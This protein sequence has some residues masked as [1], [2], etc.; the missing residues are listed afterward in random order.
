MKNTRKREF[1]RQMEQVVPWQELQALIAPH[2][3][4][5]GP[6]GGR[7]AYSVAVL[8]R[9]HFLQQW[10]AL[11]DPA[12]EEALYD[13]PVFAEFVG[14]DLGVDTVPDESTILRFRHLLEE[15]H[16]SEQML[17]LVNERLTGQGLMLRSGTVG[18]CP[19][20]CV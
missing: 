14:L 19:E 9:I 20:F 15:K 16:L 1:L 2:M 3:P 12:V 18:G 6:K 10:F 17:A 8:L 13:V 7:P 5:V 4:K 11:S